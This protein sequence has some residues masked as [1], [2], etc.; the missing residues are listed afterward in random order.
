MPSVRAS[1]R[2]VISAASC[3]SGTMLA[4]NR[5]RP[6]SMMLVISGVSTYSAPRSLASPISLAAA[7]V[8]ACGL[9]PE[10][11]WIRPTRKLEGSPFAI[12]RG[13]P[14]GRQQRV[15]PAGPL[16]RVELV[17][18]ADV[19]RA[20]EDLRRRGFAVGAADHL[21]AALLMT[22][23]VDLLER[24][25]LA[26][27]ELLRPGAIRTIGF[28]VDH[29]RDHQIHLESAGTH[30]MGLRPVSTT[31]ANTSTS[32]AAAPARL[33]ARAQA[34]M[35]APEVS[36]SSIRISRRPA[37]RERSATAKAPCTLS[38]RS[39]AVSPTCCKVALTRLSASPTTGT[40]L[41]CDTIFASAADWL[42]RRA[43]SRRQCSGT[44][45]SASASLSNACPAR[46][47]QRPSMGARSSRSEYFRPWI[48]IRETSSYRTA[49][50][51]RR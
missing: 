9:R 47:I 32:T 20:D 41:A 1:S 17:A 25:A 39:E 24:D 30:Y 42:K 16:E 49:A 40:P 18:T 6:V 38:A 22:G 7:S 2:N 21:G 19:G 34:S 44:G 5:S 26:A 45:T 28:G 50:R 36:T 37:T 48:R 14:S 29:D 3:S 35:V 27:Q 12:S 43:H 33:S 23:H 31:R 15:E 10:R 8:L 11:I 51:A 4:K 13:S 46:A